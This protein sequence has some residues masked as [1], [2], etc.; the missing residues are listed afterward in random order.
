MIIVGESEF[1]C[2]QNKQLE[3][4]YTAGRD[5]NFS[6]SFIFDLKSYT[7]TDLFCRRFLEIVKSRKLRKSC[8][9]AAVS[10]NKVSDGL[11]VTNKN[12][13]CMYEELKK[14][15]AEN[16]HLAILSDNG[17]HN[18]L[19]NWFKNQKLDNKHNMF[20]DQC[21][22]FNEFTN[23]FTVILVQDFNW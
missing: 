13:E 16:G 18:K 12:W 15:R 9:E 10:F 22:D 3:V 23:R 20:N 14:F 7:D 2:R 17:E 21:C 19:G 1:M 11:E 8:Q 6:N 4:F 5:K